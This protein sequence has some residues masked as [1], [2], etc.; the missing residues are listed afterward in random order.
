LNREGL[1][2]LL[3]TQSQLQVVGSAKS[4][5]EAAALCRRERPDLLIFDNHLPGIDGAS[6]IQSILKFAPGTRVLALVAEAGQRCNAASAAAPEGAGV[7][8]F[9]CCGRQDCMGRAMADGALAVLPRSAG[10]TCLFRAARTVAADRPW[11]PS[12]TVHRMAECL[13][14]RHQSD[15]SVLLSQREL[16][17]AELVSDGLCN[18]EIGDRLNI[19]VGTVKKHVGH[20]LNKLQLRDRLQVG[21]LFCRRPP[22]RDDPD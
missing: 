7:D 12:E 21:L 11:F 1:V 2:A 20:I 3:R 6:A 10:G 16:E 4:V 13:M 15:V 9:P 22:S 17:V 19:E 18:K 14:Q 5:A 8:R